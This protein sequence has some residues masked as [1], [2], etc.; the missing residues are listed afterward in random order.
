[1]RKGVGCPTP[2]AFVRIGERFGKAPWEIEQGPMDRVMYYLNVMAIEGEV[3][4]LLDG[5][6]DDERLIRDDGGD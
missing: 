4:G 3:M 6:G 1:M 5:M 2:L